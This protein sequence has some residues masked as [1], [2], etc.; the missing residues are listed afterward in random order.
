MRV[1]LFA[2]LVCVIAG[3]DKKKEAGVDPKSTTTTESKPTAP[4]RANINGEPVDVCAQIAKAQVETVVGTIK[5]EPQPMEGQGSMLG[6][7]TWQTEEGFAMVSTRPASEYEG[8]VRYAED[9]KEVSGIGE[10]AFS[11]KHGLLVKA[12]GKQYMLQVFIAG[13]D[14]KGDKTQALAKLALTTL[15]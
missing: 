4:K 3:C 15:K 13:G 10:K 1:T 11:T 9:A 7:C 5:G 14:D 8:T 6:Q 12:P 2:L